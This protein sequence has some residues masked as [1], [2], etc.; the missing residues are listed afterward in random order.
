L[1]DILRSQGCVCQKFNDLFSEGIPDIL[2]KLPVATP[3][4]IRT[5]WVEL[6]AIDQWPKRETTK[7]PRKSKPTPAQMRWMNSFATDSAPCWVLLN[8]PDGWIAM[9]HDAVE[10]FWSL[11]ISDVRKRLDKN[12]PTMGRILR[13][14]YEN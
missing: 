5:P 6:K 13:S 1:L 8:T 9:D 7:L 4:G 11:P 3:W 2:V 12:T 14:I 10:E